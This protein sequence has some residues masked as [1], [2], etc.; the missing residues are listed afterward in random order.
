MTTARTASEAATCKVI[1]KTQ[2]RRPNNTII[3]NLA[4]KLQNSNRNSTFSWVSLIGLSTTRPGSS[5][6]RLA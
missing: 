6:F 4:A 5:T 1:I 3:E 2:N